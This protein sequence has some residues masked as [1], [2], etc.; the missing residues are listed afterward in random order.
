MPINQ[1]V[2]PLNSSTLSPSLADQPAST[3]VL[4]TSTSGRDCSLITNNNQIPALVTSSHATFK[5]TVIDLS[6]LS[7]A[8][9]QPQNVFFSFLLARA[10]SFSFIPGI[11]LQISSSPSF[12]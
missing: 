5:F 12:A 7:Q 6:R 3:S 4:P 2:S 10:I 1:L 8:K 11:L 9:F